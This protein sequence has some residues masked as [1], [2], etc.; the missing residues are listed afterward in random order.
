MKETALKLGLDVLQPERVKGNEE[1]INVLE[2]ME[3]DL[4]AV[5]AY[6]QL[7]PK[8]VLDIPKFGCVNIHGSLLPKFRGAAPIQRAVLEGEEVTGVTIM[9][10]EEGLDTGNMLAKAST[11]VDGKTGGHFM[12]TLRF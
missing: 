10:M 7:L 12:R 1:F 4:I 8:N 9:F 5:A 2:S 3:P 11:S 6:G